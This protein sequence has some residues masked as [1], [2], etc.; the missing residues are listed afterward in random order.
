VIR[1]IALAAALAASDALA[2]AALVGSEPADGDVVAQAPAS[3]VL[4]FDEPVSPVAV[5]LLDHSGT[6]TAIS[7][8]A[9]GATVTAPLPAGLRDGPYLLSYRVASSDSHPVGGSVAFAIGSG[10]ASLAPVA[11]DAGAAAA[12]WRG[13][14]RIV[15]DLALVIA[16][17][18]ALFALLVRPFPRQAVLLPLAAAIAA[19]AALVS[20]MLD[21]AALA[22]ASAWDLAAWRAGVATT[23]GAAAG[24]AIAAAVAI[25]WGALRP[26]NRAAA[27]HLGAG[28]LLAVASFAFTGHAA[29]VVPRTLGAGVVLVHMLGA[30]FWAGALVALL[31]ILRAASATVA[32]AAL[33]RFSSRGA[34]AVALI[35]LGGTAFA[36]LEL[37]A[38]RQLVLS[39]YGRWIIVKLALLAALLVLAAWNRFRLLPALT[40]GDARAARALRGT[41]TAEIVLVSLAIGAAALLAQTPPPRGTTV[42]MEA[43]GYAVRVEVVPARAGANTIGIAFRT[44]DG[45]PFDPAEVVVEIA[46]VRAGVEPMLRAARRSGPGRYRVAGTEL[47]FPGEW[48]LAVA[49]RVSDF[50]RLVVRTEIAVR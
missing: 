18:G 35:V 28:A 29:A 30:A 20:V 17:G 36:V 11:A 19:A 37:D 49:A 47:A 6:A 21:G 34:L 43:G 12:A 33:T 15:H 38:P 24:V 50:D 39:D 1:A 40:R 26:A 25:N 8:S 46:N 10:S 5:R 41:V 13:A 4:S 23:R 42:D 7:A 14:V 32:A 31:L 3:V 9:S 16:A 27:W 48:S 22:A 44:P 2:H 45:A